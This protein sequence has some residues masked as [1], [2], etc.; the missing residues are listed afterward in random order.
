MKTVNDL[1][2]SPLRKTAVMM[3]SHACLIPVGIKQT[4]VLAESRTETFAYMT[5]RTESESNLAMRDSVENRRIWLYFL[6][7][8]RCCHGYMHT[9][10]GH[11][12]LQRQVWLCAWIMP[13]IIIIHSNQ[14]VVFV[15]LQFDCTCLCRPFVCMK[16]AWK[17]SQWTSTWKILLSTVWHWRT[18][19]YADYALPLYTQLTF[20]ADFLGISW[21]ACGIDA[22]W[23]LDPFKTEGI[24]QFFTPHYFSC[25]TCA[26]HWIKGVTLFCN[27][28]GSRDRILYKTLWKRI[29]IQILFQVSSNVSTTR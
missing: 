19:H 11:N 16:G 4:T 24:L 18:T 26:S 17:V 20:D 23:Y 27:A 21:R 7:N 1:S 2:A 6:F 29:V 28:F 10:K 13:V 22:S 15:S 8:G 14:V 9:R 3:I 12:R 5:V 25:V